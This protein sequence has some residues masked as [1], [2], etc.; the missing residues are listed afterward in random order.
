[1]SFFHP[2]EQNHW[3][4][5]LKKQPHKNLKSAPKLEQGQSMHFGKYN[6][7]ATL[8]LHERERGLSETNMLHGCG[9]FSG[10]LIGVIS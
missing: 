4:I 7:S 6:I 5:T 3:K 2:S 10:N 8:F 1:M 9:L